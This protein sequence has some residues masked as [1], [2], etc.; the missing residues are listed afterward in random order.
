MHSLVKFFQVFD[1]CD[2]GERFFWDKSYLVGED[3][4]SETGYQETAVLRCSAIFL[5]ILFFN[6]FRLRLKLEFLHCFSASYLIDKSLSF[7]TVTVLRLRGKI[8]RGNLSFT[9]LCISFFY[10]GIEDSVIKIKRQS[11]GEQ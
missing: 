3:S 11:F 4:N 6:T 9:H 5:V 8:K 2:V 10:S 7:S 1:F